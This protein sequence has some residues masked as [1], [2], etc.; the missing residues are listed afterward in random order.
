[1][2]RKNVT[3]LS[4]QNKPKH[5][6]NFFSPYESFFISPQRGFLPEKNPLDSLPRYS[7]LHKQ[8]NKLAKNLPELLKLKSVRAEVDILNRHYNNVFLNLEKENKQQQNVAI[9][10]LLMIAQAY[11]WENTDAPSN[12]I[13]AVIAK[14]LYQLCKSQQRFPALTYA[15]YILHNWQMKDANKKITLDNIEPSI[16]FTGTLDE[17][18]FIKIHVVIEAIAANALHAAYQASILSY[19]MKKN[20][21][22][23]TKENK[24]QLA[25]FLGQIADALKEAVSVLQKMKEN[26]RPDYFWSTLRLYLNGSE[27]VKNK[28]S[29]NKEEVG[30]KFEGVGTSL[31]SYKG[32]SGAQSSI[33]PALDAALGIEHKID[34]MYQTLLAF[35][36]YMPHKH[37]LFI[38]FLNHAEIKKIVISSGS[39]ELEKAWAN[40]V[41]QLKLFRLA[42]LGLVAQYIYKP[43]EKNGIHP[44]DIT[45]TGGSS[46]SDYLGDRHKST[47]E[48]LRAKL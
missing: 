23:Q 30:V 40:A 17:A 48:A 27:K 7:E 16:T 2:L 38:E 18:W 43:A 4:E 20:I 46:I 9:F 25:R 28:L 44:G 14:N 29:E 5:F 13:P 3:Q 21:T 33:I 45:G 26:C 22:L 36:Q 47:G 12:K 37:R 41:E 8:L 34:G 1:M 6:F 35:Q 10:V 11:I 32:P 24:K 31:H 15:D 39:D 19:S 42:H